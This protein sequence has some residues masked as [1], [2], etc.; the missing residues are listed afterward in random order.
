MKF[1]VLWN[2]TN[3]GAILC[4]VRAMICCHKNERAI[5][6]LRL[7]VR[8]LEVGSFP[9]LREDEDRRTSWEMNEME[10]EANAT[11]QRWPQETKCNNGWHKKHKKK[12]NSGSEI[13]HQCET[14]QETVVNWS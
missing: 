3:H 14:T 8:W 11:N 13:E 2:G 6:P 10:I 12:S 5:V 9:C 1:V 4:C 7:K